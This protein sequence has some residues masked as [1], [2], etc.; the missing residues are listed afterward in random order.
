[1]ILALLYLAF[2]IALFVGQAKVIMKAVRLR[3]AGLGRLTYALDE[4]PI[5][6]WVMLIIET[7]GLMMVATYLLGTLGITLQ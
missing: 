5:G 3:K 6:F 7:A 2:A 4:Q 1:M